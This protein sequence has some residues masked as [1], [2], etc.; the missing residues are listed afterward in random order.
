LLST[1]ISTP[2]VNDANREFLNGRLKE[3]LDL[4]IDPYKIQ[5]LNPNNTAAFK[6]QLTK[7]INLK[8]KENKLFRKVDDD[9][10][11][12]DVAVVAKKPKKKIPAKPKPKKKIE[13]IEDSDADEDPVEFMNKIN[14]LSGKYAKET[15]KLGGKK[16]KK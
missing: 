11:D 13:T 9:Y 15:A 5:H 10:D 14:A 16:K 1:H 2:L 4:K 6:G 12:E 3:Y 8:Y 7:Q